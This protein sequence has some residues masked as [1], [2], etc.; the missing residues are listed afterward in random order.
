MYK[1]LVNL[2]LIKSKISRQI[3]IKKESDKLEL[4]SSLSQSELGWKP[5]WSQA[6]SI[7]RTINWW[8]NVNNFHKTPLEACS[9]DIQ[10]FLN[11]NGRF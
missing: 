5:V 3:K 2:G 10:E 8:E 6:D 7:K 9:F 4:D 11:L 1:I